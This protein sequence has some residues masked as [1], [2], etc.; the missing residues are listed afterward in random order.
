MVGAFKSSRHLRLLGD[1]IRVW[2]VSSKI[3]NFPGNVV[4]FDESLFY[5]NIGN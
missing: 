3:S 1:A 4:R 5:L 2:Q